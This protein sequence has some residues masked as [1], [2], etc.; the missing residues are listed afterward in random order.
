MDTEAIFNNLPGALFDVQTNAEIISGA[1]T[2]MAINNAGTF[3]KSG[4]M[5]ELVFIT[6]AAPLFNNTGLLDVQAGSVE[7]AGG[8]NSAQF[9]IASGAHIGFGTGTYT[10]APGASFTGPGGIV[11]GDYDSPILVVNG[12]VSVGNFAVEGGT[13]DGTGALTVNSMLNWSA[14]MM[15]AVPA[16]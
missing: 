10:L 13:L 7:F 14:G 16:A 11:L 4:G 1:G 15:Q 2:N 6:A 5:G 12:N 8:T 3:R 9:N